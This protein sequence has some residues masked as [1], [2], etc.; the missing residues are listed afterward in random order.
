MKLRLAT[1]ISGDRYT[2][3][4]A[5]AFVERATDSDPDTADWKETA[6]VEKA[7]NGMVLKRGANSGIAFLA[8]SGLHECAVT[9]DGNI[10]IT[11]LRCYRKTVG[12]NGEPDGQLLGTHEFEYTILPLTD[13]DALSAIAKL[14]DELKTGLLAVTTTGR[15]GASYTA[16]LDIRADSFVFS[17]ANKLADGMEFRLYNCADEPKTG[18]VGLPEGAKTAM[19]TEIDGRPIAPLPIS[20]GAVE[21]TLAQWKIATVKVTF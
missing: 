13:E 18:V 2:A 1:G 7:M 14:G 11:L 15:T 21:L 4:S 19:L 5:F 3:G 17:T 8:K 6:V 12:T 16:G 9:S 10:D 20:D